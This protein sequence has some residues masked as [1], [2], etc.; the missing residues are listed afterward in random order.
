MLP[1]ISLYEYF[2]IDDNFMQNI[3]Q[4]Q[5]NYNNKIYNCSLLQECNRYGIS[6]NVVILKLNELETS[7]EKCAWP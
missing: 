7:V 4:M 6:W 1:I 3:C 2:S 5:K